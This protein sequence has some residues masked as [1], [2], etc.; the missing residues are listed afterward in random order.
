MSVWWI[1]CLH[2]DKELARNQQTINHCLI[3]ACSDMSSNLILKQIII[4]Y[5]VFLQYYTIY[6]IQCDTLLL[7]NQYV[8]LIMHCDRSVMF[9]LYLFVFNT[10]LYQILSLLGS[11]LS[12]MLFCRNKL[13]LFTLCHSFF[14][15]PLRTW[16]SNEKQQL[17]KQDFKIFLHSVMKLG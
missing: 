11:C 2:L 14:F 16:T 12:Q 15:Y 8:H 1:W 4:E 5:C 13:H 9:I 6:C 17:A 10:Y 3:N 7:W